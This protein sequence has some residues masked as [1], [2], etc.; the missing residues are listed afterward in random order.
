MNTKLARQKNQKPLSFPQVAKVLGNRFELLANRKLPVKPFP[1]DGARPHPACVTASQTS[2]PH[3]ND[4]PGSGQRYPGP[5]PDQ[6]PAGNDIPRG[7][8]PTRDDDAQLEDTTVKT[9]VM[10]T[11]TSRPSIWH[12]IPNVRNIESTDDYMNIAI[13]LLTVG[14]AFFLVMVCV[15]CCLWKCFRIKG[16]RGDRDGYDDRS[17]R[18]VESGARVRVERRKGKRGREMRRNESV[19]SARS[20]D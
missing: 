5:G 1:L 12:F 20:V 6:L 19:R 17:I 9:I 13:V 16:E 3:A 8:F 18:S 15:I 4:I 14:S 2:T 11:Q 7:R 10:S